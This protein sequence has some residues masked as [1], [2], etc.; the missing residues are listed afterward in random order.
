MEVEAVTQCLPPT[1]RWSHLG[2]IR[3]SSSDAGILVAF[4]AS[5]SAGP[6]LGSGF[7]YLRF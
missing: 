6:Y 3:P 4:T 1:R 7:G 5:V 2:R